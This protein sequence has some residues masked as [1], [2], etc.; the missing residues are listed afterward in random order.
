MPTKLS[1]T[2]SRV[3]ESGLVVSLT[4]EGLTMR[5]KGKRTTYGPLSYE[6]LHLQGAKLTATQ[7]IRQT[8]RRHVS[9]GLLATEERSGL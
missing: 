5:Q 8:R 2:L 1:K 6:W 7:H 4:P 3:T 9:R